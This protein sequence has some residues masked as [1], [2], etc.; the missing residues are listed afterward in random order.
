[1]DDDTPIHTIIISHHSK[2]THYHFTT[3]IQVNP[4]NWSCLQ[5][6][7]TVGWVSE[8][9]S[10]LQKIQWRGLAWLSV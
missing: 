4:Y 8:T 1:M 10:G 2:L 5:C 6:L 7:D 3:I 9:A